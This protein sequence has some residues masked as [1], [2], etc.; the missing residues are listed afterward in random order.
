[1][2]RVVNTHVQDKII[3]GITKIVLSCIFNR[4]SK[5]VLT[6]SLPTICVKKFRYRRRD[7]VELPSDY[8]Y[9]VLCEVLSARARCTPVRS[10]PVESDRCE[11]TYLLYFR[12]SLEFPSRTFPNG[13]RNI[14]AIIANYH[15][16]SEVRYCIS[17]CY[18]IVQPNSHLQC[19]SVLWAVCS[20]P[21]S[22]HCLWSYLPNRMAEMIEGNCVW[23]AVL[24]RFGSAGCRSMARGMTPL[25]RD[26]SS[27]DLQVVWNSGRIY[28]YELTPT[29][30][31]YTQDSTH[32]MGHVLSLSVI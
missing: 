26:L 15:L 32:F 25:L 12:P 29:A 14:H 3:M 22:Q 6:R 18:K 24:N 8:Q 13:D 5:W 17:R 27:A 23:F 20:L 1:M 21:I 16:N 28:K 11:F 9:L 7:G 31:F 2:I 4:I 10:N 19:A 30:F